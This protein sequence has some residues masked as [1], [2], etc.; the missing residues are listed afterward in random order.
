MAT[1][2]KYGGGG[3]KQFVR[4]RV[5]TAESVS[6]A[7]I[8]L[9]IVAIGFAIWQKGKVFDP[10]L[11][12]VRNDALKSTITAVEGKN[13][14][15]PSTIQTT[16]GAAEASKGAADKTAGA[17]AP[18]PDAGAEGSSDATKPA[19][20][21]EP[22]EISLTGT[23]P[24]GDTEFYTADNLYEKIDGRAPAYQGFNVQ[25]L[26]C[27]SFAITAAPG[28]FVDLYEYRFDNPVDA[29]GMF[30]LERD[31]KGKP[32]EIVADGYAADMGYFFRQGAVYVQIIASDT[33][34]ETLAKA[35]SIADIRAKDLPVNDAGLA[36][37][38]KLP[39]DGM[40]ADSVAYVAENA[41]GLSALKDVFQAKYKFNGAEIPFFVMVTSAN[42]AAQAWQSFQDFCGKFGTVE[43]LP[44][45]NGGK[46]FR[47]QV[48]GKWKVVYQRE[49]ELGGAFDADDG[50]Q[51]RA[52]IEKYLHG[53]LK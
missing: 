19:A 33:K 45:V 20:K 16:S 23:K 3:R 47:A 31:P 46:L 14:T 22:L 11:Y 53:E 42:A 51:A 48:F 44:D 10:N 32:L 1:E 37:R 26:R 9:L 24:M 27:R 28:S 34:P 15:A 2:K 30:A 50:D 17:D 12:S 38:K 41:Q 18:A 5:P 8:L 29:F 39:A 36:G 52:F 6:G 35:K 4:T 7:V 25:A 43:N 49:G 40:M 13:G 21:G